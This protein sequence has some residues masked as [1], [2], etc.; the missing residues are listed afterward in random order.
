MHRNRIQAD[1][2]HVAL[3]SSQPRNA[4]GLDKVDL[5]KVSEDCVEARQDR[6]HRIL[7][8]ANLGMGLLAEH[9][10]LDLAHIAGGHPLVIHLRDLLKGLTMGC[11]MCDC[12]MEQGLRIALSICIVSQ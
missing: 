3:D 11:L 5:G 12:R 2:S 10:G 7:G 6:S 8:A 1:A 9:D 4:A